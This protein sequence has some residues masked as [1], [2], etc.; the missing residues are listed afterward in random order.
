[1]LLPA[2]IAVAIA[3]GHWLALIW[4]FTWFLVWARVGVEAFDSTWGAFPALIFAWQ[5]AFRAMRRRDRPA[6][7]FKMWNMKP[8]SE[9][10]S[11]RDAIPSKEPILDAEFR[12]ED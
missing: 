6:F 10:Q 7:A 1:M 4:N 11:T 12:R 9:S 5:Y 2:V 8:P 3:S